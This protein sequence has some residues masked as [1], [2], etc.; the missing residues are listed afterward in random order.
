MHDRNDRFYLFCMVMLIALGSLICAYTSFHI[1]YIDSDY[2]YLPVLFENLF[3]DHGLLS[4]WFLTPAPYF[5]PDWPLYAL[6]YLFTNTM[7]SSTFIYMLLQVG[8]F[9]YFSYFLNKR[10]NSYPLETTIASMC[11]L[12]VFAHTPFKGIGAYTFLMYSATHFG[13]FS[14]SVLCTGLMLKYFDKVFQWKSVYIY[15]MIMGLIFATTLS[16]KLLIAQYTFP[17]SMTLIWAGI[18]KLYPLKLCIVLSV[19]LG[20]ASFLGDAFSHWVIAN[21][22]FYE[23]H[24]FTHISRNIKDIK[25][26]FWINHTL[27]P[28]ASF[29]LILY[30]STSVISLIFHN[31]IFKQALFKKQ[32]LFMSYFSLLSSFVLLCVVCFSSMPVTSRYFIPLF[33]L[34]VMLGP[35]L[36]LSLFPKE[37][38]H[39]I[40]RSFLL[41]SVISTGYAWKL[42][43]S[44]GLNMHWTY[45]PSDISCIDHYTKKY[46]LTKGIA[47]YWD[48]KYIQALSRN[49][50]I[51]GQYKYNLKEFHWITTKDFYK[52]KYDFAV[53]NR[54][55]DSRSL[56][57]KDLIIK[58]NGKPLKTMVCGDRMLLIY[59]R[60]SLV[61]QPAWA[62]F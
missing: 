28:I 45:Y 58:L 44:R 46:H 5:F 54:I 33:F 48:A 8:L 15:L 32:I 55:D 27:H 21:P 40:M 43:L 26:I 37:K 39:Y 41:L 42:T 2:M 14:I 35:S 9:F 13:G 12:I 16:D 38:H 36:F 25:H 61:T 62:F 53:V 34:P 30:Y 23:I 31:K 52:R 4:H 19:F 18:R 7:F 20:L 60:G 10:L 1:Y 24:W 47:A 56:L 17:I 3:S 6:A 50:L 51:L 11:V 59:H 22:K 29:Y 57:D 49:H